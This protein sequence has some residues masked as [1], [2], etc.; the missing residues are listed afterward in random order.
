MPRLIPFQPSI[1]RYRFSTTLERRT[2]LFDVRW[3][4]RADSWY[5][6]IL[7]EDESPLARGVKLVL[8]AY[9]AIRSAHADLPTGLMFAI[10]QSGRGVEAGFDDLGTRV[11]VYHY[12]SDEVQG[13]L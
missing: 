2:Y 9:L 13:I 5:I 8:G 12:T 7:D 3:N 11:V 4:T 1:P 10:D 6:D